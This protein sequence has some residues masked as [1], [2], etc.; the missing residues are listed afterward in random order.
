MP[1]YRNDDDE[2]DSPIVLAVGNAAYGAF[3]R[4][5]GY[6]S[7]HRTDGWVPAATAREICS[8]AEL[9]SLLTV[10]VGKG[11]ALV[12]APGDSC[13]CLGEGVVWPRGADGEVG[14]VLHGFLRRN[15]SRAEND[16]DRAKRRELK[17]P[18]LRA[19]VKARDCDLCRYCAV[20]VRWADRKTGRGGVLDH[21]DPR[22]ADGARNLVVACRS[23]NGRK[24]DCTPE[25]AGM[26]LLPP[27]IHAGSTAD[28]D[29]INGGST[30]RTQIGSTPDPDPD[31]DPHPARMLPDQRDVVT[32][33]DT[34]APE[35][36]PI[37][38]QIHAAMTTG[39]GGAGPGPRPRPDAGDAGPAG[40]RPTVGPPDTPRGPLYPNPYLRTHTTTG[41]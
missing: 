41:G 32:D 5:R 36:A 19:A 18:Q 39:M 29:R 14:Y 23:C 37:S 21:I 4:L 26:V 1:W 9:S 17:D 27:P 3:Q 6:A 22:A 8:R 25:A 16:V 10:R 30:D 38:G 15:P 33:V 28:P 24:K 31:S 13:A 11:A 34:G 7:K 12:H 40:Y 35:T 2:Y 20:T